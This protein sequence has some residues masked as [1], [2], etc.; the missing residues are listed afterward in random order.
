MYAKYLISLHTHRMKKPLCIFHVVYLP[1]NAGVFEILGHAHDSITMGRYGKRY[2][3]KVL[4]D[5]IVK[6]DYKLLTL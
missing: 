5:A 6:L 2:Q 3:P 4:L 1:D